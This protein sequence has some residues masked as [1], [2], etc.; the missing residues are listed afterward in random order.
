MRY[1]PLCRCSLR[2]RSRP[3]V[4]DILL[5][6]KS[7]HLGPWLVASRAV[8]GLGASAAR[9]GGRA[10]GSVANSSCPRSTGQVGIAVTP[11]PR[12]RC[13]PRRA[14]AA[15]PRS[16][17]PDTHRVSP[18]VVVG[19]GPRARPGHRCVRARSGSRE[20]ARGQ[21]ASAG[22][23]A[24]SCGLRRH[25]PRGQGPPRR[26]TWYLRKGG[27]RQAS[28]GTPGGSTM[29]LLLAQEFGDAYPPQPGPARPSTG[30]YTRILRSRGPACGR[31]APTRST[32]RRSAPP[33]TRAGGV[34]RPGRASR[35][36]GG[37][38]HRRRLRP[39]DARGSGPCIV[40]AVTGKESEDRSR[41]L[42]GKDLELA[43]RGRPAG[44]LGWGVGTDA[45]RA[46]PGGGQPRAG[47]P[48]PD[49]DRRRLEPAPRPHDVT[50]TAAS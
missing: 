34:Y 11:F 7:R 20:Y 22:L 44:Q 33:A 3:R 30:I 21:L 48:G 4:L 6:R 38:G 25:S 5:P 50:G 39:H 17:G 43:E 40:G 24:L 13:R 29:S 8:I 19:A 36:P 26:K 16:C 45:E 46:R 27:E 41:R 10:R 31:R 42:R 28:V 23:S 35:C 37:G 15:A 18:F 49:D 2:G 9:R 12:A 47:R 32:A 1:D 14:H